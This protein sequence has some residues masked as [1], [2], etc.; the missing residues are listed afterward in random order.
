MFRPLFSLCFLFSLAHGTIFGY[1][2]HCDICIC[3]HVIV[4]YSTLT[5]GFGVY[6]TSQWPFEL[7]GL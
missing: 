2:L 6:C 4:Y 1:M 5:T 3:S 7:C